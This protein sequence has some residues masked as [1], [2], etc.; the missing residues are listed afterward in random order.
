[1]ND[2][3]LSGA[4]IGSRLKRLR[5]DLPIPD[6]AKNTGISESALRMYERGERIPRDCLK[7]RLAHYYDR[8]VGDIFF[9]ENF[10]LREH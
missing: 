7:I 10:T 1:M 2:V 5:G 9:A 8:P 4:E 6:L 3:L